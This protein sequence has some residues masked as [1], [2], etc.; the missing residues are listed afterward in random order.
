MKDRGESS[1]AK[2]LPA[3]SSLLLLGQ[4]VDK[5]GVSLINLAFEVLSVREQLLEVNG[6]LVQEHA[7]NPGSIAVAIR[8]LDDC[9]DVVAHHLVSVTAL[10]L[11]KHRDVNLGKHQLGL[12]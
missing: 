11:V 1:H 7:R 10:H 4:R 2:R 5:Q 8:L 9:E 3:R 12:A 6:R